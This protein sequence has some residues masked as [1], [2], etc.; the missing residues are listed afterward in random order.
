MPFIEYLFLGDALQ[1]CPQGPSCCTKDLEQKLG[2]W[3]VAQYR[4][5]LD[6]RSSEI[7]RP[8]RQK[9][10]EL[11]GKRTIYCRHKLVKFPNLLTQWMSVMKV[12]WEVS[13]IGLE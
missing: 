13:Y 4:Q 3:S 8:L 1:I 11:G 10:L 6:E 2:D 7:A 5:A 9:A 12:A